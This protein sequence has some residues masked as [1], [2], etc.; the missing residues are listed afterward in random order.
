MTLPGLLHQWASLV[1]PQDA[2]AVLLALA[3]VAT[4]GVG[5]VR[6]RLDVG[7]HLPVVGVVV[8]CELSLLL[9]TV[10]Q[11]PL[12]R[13]W[14]AGILVAGLLAVRLWRG[15]RDA[16]A[17]AG[18]GGE[19]ASGWALLAV[20]ATLAAILLFVRLGSSP[21][22]LLT[23]E[24]SVIEGFGESA[25]AGADAG[26]F[27]LEA[28]LWDEGLVSRGDHSLLYGAPTY[29]LLR[30]SGFEVWQL[31]VVAA[32]LAIA[33]VPAV[34][35]MA[36]R[37]GA[38]VAGAAALVLTVSLPLLH[39][40]RY[41]TSLSGTLLGVLLATWAC[42]DFV[43]RPAPQWWRGPLAGVALAVAT[44]GYSPGRLVVLG[45]LGVVAVATLRLTRQAP[46]AWAGPALL[47]AVLVGFWAFQAANHASRRFFTARGEQ[48][49]T[50]MQQPEY[51]K[52]FLGRAVSPD[53]LTVADRVEL[54]ARV[55]ARRAP[56]L[57]TVVTAGLDRRLSFDDVTGSDPPRLALVFPPLL[58]FVAFGLLCSLRR[59]RRPEHVT[60]LVWVAVIC[61]P[62]LL[63]T[64]VDAHRGMLLVVPLTLWAAIGL[65][66]A[67]AAMRQLGVAA[68]VRRSLGVALVALGTWSAAVAIFPPAPTPS[69]FG[70]ALAAEL[71]S[72]RGTVVL[73]S[74]ADHREVGRVDLAMLE[75]QR[76]S[77]RDTGRLLEERILRP[78]ADP[79]SPD[80]YWIR[81]LIA[82]VGRGTLLLAPADRFYNV[83]FALQEAGT[84]VV[85][86]GPEDARFWRASLGG[87]DTG[88]AVPA[89]VP[90]IVP[91]ATPCPTPTPF[92]VPLRGGPQTPL[93]TL[94]P[95]KVE[96]SFAEPRIDQTLAGGPIVLGGVEYARGIGMHAW[97]RMTYPVPAGATAFQAV[98]GL[99]WNVRDC[100]VALVRFEVLGENGELLWTSGLVDNRTPPQRV[101]VD[102]AGRREITLVVTDGENGR[103]C[104]HGD[105]ADPSYLLSDGA[106]AGGAR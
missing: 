92:V 58:P 67:A 43:E 85:E 103:D 25:R 101:L 31:R 88:G 57:L 19:R 61:G 65:D 70:R 105:W 87:A 89:E 80:P 47:V 78:I 48:I 102:V 81:E 69:P 53:A 6:R 104:D 3:A 94:E 90:R 95:T 27:L 22:L 36:R 30:A 39:Y 56:E 83:A 12:R 9:A 100:E 60:L 35:A 7:R 15:R 42:W 11:V 40:G 84:T 82:A 29:A 50:F 18:S 73:A 66:E 77:P 37:F 44:L 91:R 93:L 86:K 63:T 46:G 38:G 13:L 10:L 20:A 68:V 55:V 1:W 4:L 45:L 76:S 106:P 72:I 5:L 21:G 99:S 75:R 79:P 8:V 59:W 32:L 28:A 97:C 23:W 64:R 14:P 54:A 33:C 52:E 16:E 96:S 24:P 34:F 71:A 51:L 41:G 17:A 74:T 98:V 62:L 49:L 26:E 2:A